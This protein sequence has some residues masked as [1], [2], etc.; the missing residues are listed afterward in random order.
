MDSLGSGRKF[1]IGDNKCKEFVTVHAGFEMTHIG[2]G[3][4]TPAVGLMDETTIETLNM[5]ASTA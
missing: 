4:V 5:R 3:N 1:S 2:N